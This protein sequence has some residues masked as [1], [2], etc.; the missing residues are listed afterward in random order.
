MTRLPVAQTL[1]PKPASVALSELAVTAGVVGSGI[2][3]CF[4]G[5]PAPALC[6]LWRYCIRYVGPDAVH[7]VRTQADVRKLAKVVNSVRLVVVYS[8]RLCTAASWVI[9][10]SGVASER[11]AAQPALFC[12]AERAEMDEAPGPALVLRGDD[13]DSVALA[14]WLSTTENE[15]PDWAAIPPEL[16]IQ[17]NPVLDATILTANSSPGGSGAL[18]SRAVLQGLLAGATMTRAMEEAPV[19][20]NPTTSLEDYESVRRLLQSRI[21][22]GVDEAF[23][24][25]AADMVSRANVYMDVRRTVGSNN[26]FGGSDMLIEDGQRPPR[27]LVSRRELSDLGNVRSRMV[28]RMIEFLQQQPDGHERYRRL[29]LVGRA[30]QRDGW[31]GAEINGLIARLRPWSSK[32]VRTHFDRLQRT[33]M[34]A[35][36]R[37]QP[38]G[39]WRYGLPED[40]TRRSSAFGW[41]PSPQDITA[42]SQDS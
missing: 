36:K 13:N 19:T 22:A 32:Q 33:G 27:E 16:I 25:L 15:G 24:P 6:Q 10:M 18:R 23:D 29:G 2:T 42:R 17:R 31:R 37:E 9:Q 11:R 4:D 40:L 21:V 3:L 35:A 14:Q 38:N 20:T 8:P 28:R 39:P 30:P 1:P 41:L 12:T 5:F 26:P 34:I 7:H